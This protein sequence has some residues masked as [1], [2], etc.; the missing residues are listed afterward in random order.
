MTPQ[1]R[2]ERSAEA[3]WANDAASKWLGMRLDAIGPGTRRCH[4]SRFS[5]IT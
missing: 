1:E 5:R 2:A 4:C 3:M